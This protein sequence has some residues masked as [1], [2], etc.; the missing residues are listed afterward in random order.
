MAAGRGSDAGV[1]ERRGPAVLA[2]VPHPLRI[3]RDL[4]VVHRDAQV[5]GEPAGHLGAGDPAP[6]PLTVGGDEDDRRLGDGGAGLDIAL[7]AAAAGDELL[8]VAE[9]TPPRGAVQGAAPVVPGSVAAAPAAQ[10]VEQPH[11]PLP[12]ARSC[13]T[14][15]SGTSTALAAPPF[16]E[17]QDDNGTASRAFE[18]GGNDSIEESS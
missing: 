10:S 3:A 4:G 13:D 9:V 18:R 17:W 11:A 8:E 2:P 7:D 12:V 15:R 16:P 6:G 1:S 5:T 14:A